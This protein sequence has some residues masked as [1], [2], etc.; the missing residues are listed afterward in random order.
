ML[1]MRINAIAAAGPDVVFGS[2]YLSTRL[3]YY[4]G[5]S[6]AFHTEFPSR[7]SDIWCG[8]EDNVFVACQ[9]YIYQFDGTLWTLA[10]MDDQPV[11]AP[12]PDAVPTLAFAGGMASG[13]AGCRS[14]GGWRS[15]PWW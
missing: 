2:D 6:W 11:S 15:R 13:N 1:F 12:T 3:F 10:S 14:G 4:D 8:G 5:K 9:F 7:I